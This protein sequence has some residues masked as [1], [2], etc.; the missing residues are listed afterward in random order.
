MKCDKKLGLKLNKAFRFQLE[1]RIIVMIYGYCRCSTTETAGLQSFSHQEEELI[2]HGVSPENIYKERISG[3]KENKPVLNSLLDKCEIGSTIK[4]YEL[5]RISRSIKD[6][7]N[8]VEIIKSKKLRLELIMNNIIIDFTK[9]T[10]DPFT[11]FFLNIMM[12]FNSLEVSVIRERVKSG[13]AATDKKIGRPAMSKEKLESDV[14]FLKY[15]ARWKN[16]EINLSEMSRLYGHSRKNC[17]EKIA[18]YEN[19]NKK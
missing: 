18:V 2:K 3:V 4:V 6:F 12:A 17:R 15:Y 1:R 5:S 8:T 7:N 9:D 16:K 14:L 19:R 10:V 11:E 13:M